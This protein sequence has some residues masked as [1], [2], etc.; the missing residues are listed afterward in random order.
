L[1]IRFSW[2]TNDIT[3]IQTITPYCGQD[4]SIK[5]LSPKKR[6]LFKYLGL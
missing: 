5:L 2:N 4:D 1:D 3:R 6:W